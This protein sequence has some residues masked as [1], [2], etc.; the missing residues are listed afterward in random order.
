MSLF[1]YP[2]SRP[3]QLGLCGK[4]TFWIIAVLYVTF[5]TTINVISLGYEYNPVLSRTYYSTEKLWYEHLPFADSLVSLTLLCNP[6]QL[7]P[8]QGQPRRGLFASELLT[9]VKT[10]QLRSVCSHIKSNG[11]MSR[12]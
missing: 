5:I 10:L 1:E 3:I 12:P 7:S 8:N 4:I 11:E 9:L 2:V 6:V